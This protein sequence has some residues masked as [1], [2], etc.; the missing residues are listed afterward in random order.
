MKTYVKIEGKDVEPIVQ[1]LARLALDLP[2]VC[3]WDLNMTNMGWSSPAKAYSS[4]ALDEFGLFM[5][6][7]TGFVKEDCDRIISSTRGDL[8][9]AQIYYEWRNPPTKEE[10]DKLRT[11][12]EDILEP[13][14]RIF[15]IN[16]K[17]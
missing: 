9:D 6:M 10:L 17:D 4:P 7:D 8:G 13:Y 12:I 5:G 2:E 15:R 16:N 1:K 3:V 14:N 11:E